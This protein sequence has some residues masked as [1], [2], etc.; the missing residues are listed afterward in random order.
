MKLED[1]SSVMTL[2][3]DKKNYRIV[4]SPRRAPVTELG[5]ETG[6]VDV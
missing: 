2:F 6:C 1:I 4:L 5:Q 3:V